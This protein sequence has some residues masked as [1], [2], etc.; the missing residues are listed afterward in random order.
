MR[1]KDRRYSNVARLPDSALHGDTV[2]VVVGDRLAA[3]R[4]EVVAYHG[5]DIV[6][7]G[8]LVDGDRVTITRF[9]EIADGVKVEVR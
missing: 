2:Y 9:T 8:D 5:E 1:L 3:R 7:R 4:V 6:V